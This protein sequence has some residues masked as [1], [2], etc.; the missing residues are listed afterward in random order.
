MKTALEIIFAFT[1]LTLYLALALTRKSRLRKYQKDIRTFWGHTIGQY[2]TGK[3]DRELFDKLCEIPGFD[4]IPLGGY[5][6]I[7]DFA[8]FIGLTEILDTVLPDYAN[9]SKFNFKCAVIDHAPFV[10]LYDLERVINLHKISIEAHYPG[11]TQ[12][13]SAMNSA[14]EFTTKQSQG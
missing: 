5:N 14:I 1:F 9:I 12:D 2:W 13:L 11:I 6:S 10:E 4:D 3:F 7:T 8:A